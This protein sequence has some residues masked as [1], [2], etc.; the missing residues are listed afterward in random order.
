[1]GGVD[2]FGGQT[3]GPGIS[4]TLVAALYRQHAPRKSEEKR[5]SLISL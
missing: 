3:C 1:M 5:N 2:V 4:K